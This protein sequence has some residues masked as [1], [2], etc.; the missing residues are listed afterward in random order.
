MEENSQM[1]Q[2]A[3]QSKLEMQRMLD[4][5]DHIS[6]AEDKGAADDCVICLDSISE[7]ATIVPCDHSNF[8][9]LCLLNWLEQRPTC[10]LCKRQAQTIRYGKGGSRD[11]KIYLVPQPPRPATPLASA[12][13]RT[14]S[15]PTRIQRQART[16]GYAANLE[17]SRRVR[18][19]PLLQDI[20]DPIS[21]RKYI[22]RHNLY[23]LHVGSNRLSRF[24]ELTP[25]AF[26]DPALVS[27][28]RKWIRRELQVFDHL[29][30]DGSR[31]GSDV[32]KWANNA[33]FLL[34]YIIGI[35]KSVEIKGAG[36]HA[37]NMISEHLGRHHTRLFLHELRAWMR[38]P[39]N[40]LHEWDQQV[41]YH[42]N[43]GF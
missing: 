1:E 35:L 12:P 30:T 29:Y 38:S 10:P 40:H 28:S 8:D 6:K 42:E 39:Y 15:R 36:A 14:L 23:S 26:S 21:R 5:T 24:V 34:E 19:P 17:I 37:E 27:R 18:A 2:L 7:R 13:R 3:L 9:L 31:R 41:Q 4:D 33:E 32:N 16:Q 22:Y 11:V 25:R 20:T 43:G